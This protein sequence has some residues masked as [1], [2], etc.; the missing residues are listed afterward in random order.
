MELAFQQ[1]RQIRQ[2]VKNLIS[3]FTD[4]QLHKIPKGFNNN[5]IWNYGHII[6][7][8]HLLTI[9]LGNLPLQCDDDII[10]QFK[11]GSSPKEIEITTSTETLLQLA[12]DLPKQTQ[13]YYHQ[14]KFTSFKT[15]PTSFGVTLNNIHDALAFNNIHEGL[16]LGYMMALA[17]AL[18]NE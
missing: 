14:N 15:Y 17:K 6:V 4:N 5:L 11:K 13:A 3:G 9:G 8:E 16:H 2:N 7:V 12:E 1:H 10:N 18:K